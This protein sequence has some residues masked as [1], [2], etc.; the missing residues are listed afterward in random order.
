MPVNPTYPGVYIEELPSAVR[1]ITGVPTSIAAFVGAAPRGR[2][3]QPVHVTSLADYE[4]AFGRLDASSPMS[5]AVSQFYQNQGSEAQ[6]VRI[7]SHD[8]AA[9]IDL[10]NGVLLE[11]AEAGKKG[12]G[13]R[14]RVDAVSGDPTLYTLTIHPAEGGDESVIGIKKQASPDAADSLESKLANAT[15]VKLKKKDAADRPASPESAAGAAATVRP[16]TGSS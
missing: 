8:V 1:T 15:L 12:N 10:G 6:I 13:L 5:Y 3:D 11:A 16:S 7:V 14:A 2:T 4:R 9:T